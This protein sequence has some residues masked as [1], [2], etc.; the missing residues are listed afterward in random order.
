[1]SEEIY[2]G[3]KN[4]GHI[5]TKKI[6]VTYKTQE[7]YFRI[8]Q[9]FALSQAVIDLL[10]KKEIELIQMVYTGK[11][12]QIKYLSSIKQWEESMNEW[13]NKEGIQEDPQKV[14]PVKEMLAIEI[15][16]MNGLKNG[17]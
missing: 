8:F 11:N 7:H 6:Y 17:R 5:G 16:K 14:L 12:K 15:I 9:G 4:I 2:L 1:M 13:N 3:E 10:K